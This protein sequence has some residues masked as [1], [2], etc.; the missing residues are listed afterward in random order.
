MPTPRL[1]PVQAT[2]EGG[3]IVKTCRR[4]CLFTIAGIAVCFIAGCA[5][6]RIIST[7]RHPKPP[8]SETQEKIPPTSDAPQTAPATSRETASLELVRQAERHLLA[9]DPHHAIRTLEKALQLNPVEGQN[10]YLMAEAWIQLK[11]PK[12]ALEYHRLAAM[13]LPPLAVWQEKMRLQ[14]EKIKALPAVE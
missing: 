14:E 11:Q 13:Y 9:H 5:P 4:M 2:A 10:Y 3:E 7:P 8:P 6:E 1:R 12:Q